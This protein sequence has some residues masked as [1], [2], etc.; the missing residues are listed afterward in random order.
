MEMTTSI[1]ELS[2]S[3]SKLQSQITPIK[4]DADNPFFKSKYASLPAVVEHAKKLLTDNNLAITQF[5]TTQND[6]T[7]LATILMHTSGEY[8]KSVMPL[9]LS[10]KTPQ[11]QGSAITYARRYAF[12]AALGLTAEDDDDDGNAASKPEETKPAWYKPG[13]DTNKYA[14]VPMSATVTTYD[15]PS[16]EVSECKNCG[17]TH[18][19]IALTKPD[20]PRN[21]NRPYW[22]CLD[23]PPDKCFSSWVRGVKTASELTPDADKIPGNPF[24]EPPFSD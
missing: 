3:L 7:A 21:P 4:K 13:N 17:S 23:C 16:S 2:A 22:K 24:N 9:I 15:H 10:Q 12:M 20:N 11:G 6:E 18:M 14:P 1:K 19:T 5:I 8:I